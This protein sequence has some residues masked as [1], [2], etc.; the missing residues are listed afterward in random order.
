MVC[1]VLVVDISSSAAASVVFFNFFVEQEVGASCEDLCTEKHS[2][3][4]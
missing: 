3:M 1:A 4:L 2:E